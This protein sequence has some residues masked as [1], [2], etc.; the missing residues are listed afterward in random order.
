M[1]RMY[2]N[3]EEVV[4]DKTIEVKE[5]FLATSSTILKNC[6]P[7][8]WEITKD[9]VNNFYFP[10][11]YSKCLIYNDN[12]LIFCGV[13]K[14]TGNITLNPREPHYCDLQV[15][16]FK[17][18]LSEGETLDFV[19]S[20]KTIEEAIQMVVDAVSQYG[21]VVGN[22]ETTTANDIIG[23]YST[24]NKTAYDVLQYLADV[25]QCRWFTRM[26]DE[27]TV[28]VDFY[29]AD[30][31]EQKDDIEYTKEFFEANNIQDIKFSYSTSD[32]RNKQIMLSEEIYGSIDYNEIVLSDGYS[33]N[34]LVSAKVGVLK[35]ITVNGVQKTFATSE[36]K[37]LGLVADFYYTVGSNA[38]ESDDLYTAGTEIGVEFTPLVKG[39]QIVINDD[40]I[41]RIGN[42]TGRNGIISRY[43][44]RNDSLSNDELNNI[45]QSYIKY[46]GKPEI[47]LKVLTY[48]KDLY[49]IGNLVYFDAPLDD[50]KLT[51]MVKSKTTQII[52]TTGDIFYTYQLSSSYNS[53]SAINYFDNQRAKASG[54]IQSGEYIT[55]NIDIENSANII[56]DNVNAEQ[57]A[58]D[59]N[60]VLNS[61]LNSPFTN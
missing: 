39:R 59:G 4:C 27:D 49:N 18:F 50:L 29:D 25:T 28:A 5:E 34:F 52:A 1:I 8:S 7:K 51:Y 36:D 46:K 40:E 9:Y 22:I 35:N 43:E 56:W 10:K 12:N 20:E 33:Q 2:I 45:G 19:I 38:I 24:L 21:F 55:R 47:T 6:Y 61:I 53:E 15:L 16:D 58:I 17:T 42:Q 57:I 54:N 48:N 60:N 31:M 23:A 30:L 41:T 14:N 37:E 3:N 26:I 44:T 11:D 32:Y 13:V